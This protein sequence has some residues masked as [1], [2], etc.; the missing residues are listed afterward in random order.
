MPVKPSAEVCAGFNPK[1]TIPLIID[2]GCSGAEGNTDKLTVRDSELYT[3]MKVE[4]QTR[5]SAAG[6]VVNSAYYGEGARFFFRAAFCFY[7]LWR[8]F[9]DLLCGEGLGA[10]HGTEAKGTHRVAKKR[11]V[12]MG[13]RE[14]SHEAD[15]ALKQSSL[16]SQSILEIQVGPCWTELVGSGGNVIREFM[17]AATELFGRHCL[18]QFEECCFLVRAI[19]GRRHLQVRRL[20]GNGHVEKNT[21]LPTGPCGRAEDDM[22]SVQNSQVRM[23]RANYETNVV[24]AK[25]ELRIAKACE[26]IERKSP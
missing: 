15:V 13:R 25:E 18:L 23:N 3:G 5:K 21:K 26:S 2:A 24:F 22:S 9:C 16:S 6:T 17:Q 8:L 20:G 7:S 10:K 19:A 1:R 12:D 11:Y 14:G 4:R